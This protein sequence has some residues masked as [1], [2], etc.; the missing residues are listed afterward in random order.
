MPKKYNEIE[1]KD[2]MKVESQGHEEVEVL[3]EKKDIKSV[4]SE[5]PTKVKRGL[6]SRLVTG[7]VGPDGLP[8]VGTYVNE[9]IIKPAIKNIIVDG[10]TS[11][12]NMIMYGEKGGPNRGGRTPYS[13]GGR[14]NY[15]PTTNYGA[16]YRSSSVDPVQ[17]E[18]VPAR[19]VSQGVE[20]YLIADRYDASHVLT[21]LTES[22]DMYGS[23]SVADYYDSIG[24]PS[25]YTD[26]NYGWT[27]DSIVKAVIVPVRGGYVIKFPS[28]EVI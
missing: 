19:A 22:A 8:G 25:K 11:G 28:V 18:R 15:R 9:E 23:V 7:I 20:E 5:K 26:N 10:V 21:T 4:V 6:L 13:G 27:I 3:K 14:S 1:V 17:P 12:I 2:N 16:N 24:V